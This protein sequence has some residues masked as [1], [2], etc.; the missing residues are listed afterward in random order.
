MD[1]ATGTRASDAERQEIVAQLSRHLND[2]RIDLGEYDER[3]AAVYAT[4]TRDELQRVL[5]DLPP[6]RART[7]SAQPG[8]RRR[9]P[10]WQRIELT[11]WFGVG[12]LCVVIWA[13]VSLG[14]GEFTYPWPLWVIGP[15]GGV[16]IFR[17]AAGWESRATGALPKATGLSCGGPRR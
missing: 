6:L 11:A 8:P 17:M 13:L 9:V 2:G 12:L 15:W 1:I 5:A 3:V 4:T 14:L 10:L 7:V 16:L